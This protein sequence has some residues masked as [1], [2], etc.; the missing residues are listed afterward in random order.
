MWTHVD[1]SKT[2]EGVIFVH[3]STLM[4]A[5]AAAARKGM[6]NCATA[7]KSEQFNTNL[8]QFASSSKARHWLYFVPRLQI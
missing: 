1:F 8:T 3:L 7:A 5:A 4:S 2:S 6:D